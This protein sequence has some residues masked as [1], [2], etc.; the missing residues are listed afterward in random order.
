MVQGRVLIELMVKDI[1]NCKLISIA[2]SSI[3]SC[4]PEAMARCPGGGSSG[5]GSASCTAG[6][7]E[8]VAVPGTSSYIF[9][10]FNLF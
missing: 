2:I 8:N 10:T 1:P 6:V 9:I 7:T 4:V 3:G 5:G